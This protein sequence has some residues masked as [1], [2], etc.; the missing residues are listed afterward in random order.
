MAGTEEHVMFYGRAVR[1]KNRMAAKTKASPRV[2]VRQN[3]YLEK[4]V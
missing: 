1:G 4:S 3:E 2:K